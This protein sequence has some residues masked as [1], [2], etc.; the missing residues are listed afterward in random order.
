MQ[1]SNLCE[2][3]CEIGLTKDIILAENEAVFQGMYIARYI[4]LKQE[5]KKV[6]QGDVG[7]NKLIPGNRRHHVSTNYSPH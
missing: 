7:P 2:F 1:I 4:L 5:L 3:K 6:T